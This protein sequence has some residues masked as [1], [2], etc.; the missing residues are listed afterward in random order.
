MQRP[1]LVLA[2]AT[3][4]IAGG[5]HE[6]DAGGVQQGNDAALEDTDGVIDV[7]HHREAEAFPALQL[8]LDRL[9]LRGVLRLEVRQHEVQV[10][11]VAQ[12]QADNQDIAIEKSLERTA[13]SH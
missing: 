13:H 11:L 9:D 2:A 12:Q 1:V 6:V 3:D 10:G 8:C 7:A 4:R 5:D